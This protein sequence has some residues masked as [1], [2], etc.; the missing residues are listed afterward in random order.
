MGCRIGMRLLSQAR[1]F[2][3]AATRPEP[4]V[5]VDNVIVGAG[6]VGLAVAERLSRHAG[7]TF[8]LEKHPSF[9]Q[10][11][12]SRNSEVIHAGI[13]YPPTSL[14]TKLCIKGNRLMYAFCKRHDIPH[15]RVGKWIVGTGEEQRRY[16][17]DLKNRADA[18]NVDV[19]WVNAERVRKEEPNVIAD[20]VLESTTTGIVDSHGVMACLESK[21][22]DRGVETFYNTNVASISP[23]ASNDG[24]LVSTI[25]T[26]TAETLTIHTKRL[27]NASGLSSDVIGNM[28]PSTDQTPHKIFPCKGHYYSFLPSRPCVRRLIYPVP[29]RNLKGLGIHCTV[30]LAGR[31]K[32]GPDALYIDSK[33]DY[34]I[35]YDDNER[36][37]NFVRAIRMY[38]KGVE[39][40]DIQ[41]DYTGIRPKLSGPGEPFRDFVI[42]QPPGYEGWI[43]LLGIESPGL[44]ASLAIAEK[45]EHL[46]GYERS[47]DGWDDIS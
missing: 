29:E 40:D 1:R 44:T 32:F 12:S 18:L 31:V 27:I 45:V 36:K 11:T 30:D 10:E 13:Y 43:N 46:L 39:A 41:A 5:H 38:L 28:L 20:S 23:S 26:T 17:E 4:E 24:Y 22:L 34:A 7:S 33:S 8:V 16:L 47:S 42:E 9:G 19:R 21:A 35:S 3:T 14:K 25:S 6:V 2:A 37:R 15:R